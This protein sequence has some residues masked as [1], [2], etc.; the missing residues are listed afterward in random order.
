MQI[1]LYFIYRVIKIGVMWESMQGVNKAINTK[2][3]LNLP[4]CEQVR[5]RQV[6]LNERKTLVNTKGVYG[7]KFGNETHFLSFAAIIATRNGNNIE[8]LDSVLLI[9]HGKLW[10]SATT[11]SFLNDK[12]SL[13]EFAQLTHTI[14]CNHSCVYVPHFTPN[15]WIKP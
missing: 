10:E 15:A 14:N 9:S 1:I 13:R 7:S 5:Q 8:W 3:G 2:V 6:T 4:M 12:C 11:K